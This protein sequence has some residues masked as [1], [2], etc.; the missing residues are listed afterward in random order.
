MTRKTA[1]GL[2]TTENPEKYYLFL[3]PYEEHRFTKCPEC[4]KKTKIRKFPLVITIDPKTL[5][6]LNKSCKFC[7]KCQLIIARKQEVEN[8]MAFQFS[9]VNPEIIGNDYLIIGTLERKDWQG[10]NKG[11]ISSKEMLERVIVFKDYWKFEVIPPR[12]EFQ[13]PE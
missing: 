13:K 8:L 3:N 12:W 4:D 11:L 9:S 2:G 5:L 7:E 6:L 10:G 1:K